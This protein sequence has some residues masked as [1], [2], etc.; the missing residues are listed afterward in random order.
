[1]QRKRPEACFPA[2]A[3]PSEPPKNTDP[4]T[5]M[6]L[7]VSDLLQVCAHI[8]A[9]NRASPVDQPQFCP[10]P[11]HQQYEHMSAVRFAFPRPDGRYANR[12]RDPWWRGAGM[13]LKESTK[14]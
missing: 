2:A 10:A 9:A 14:S 4:E 5:A 11:I 8:A 1:M 13:W 12:I 7:R 6:P 3:C